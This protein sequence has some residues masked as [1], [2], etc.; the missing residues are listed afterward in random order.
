M[1]SLCRVRS[2]MLFHRAILP[3][4]AR[5]P[6]HSSLAPSSRSRG[7]LGAD[8]VKVRLLLRCSCARCTRRHRGPMPQPHSASPPHTLSPG[9]LQSQYYGHPGEARADWPQLLPWLGE[10]SLTLFTTQVSGLGK[11]ADNYYINTPGEQL[12]LAYLPCDP[13]EE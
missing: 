2:A 7:C 6:R 13:D 10:C 11:V 9:I 8:M 5:P 1:V 3:A 4:S 12:N